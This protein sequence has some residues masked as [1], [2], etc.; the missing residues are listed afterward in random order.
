MGVRRWLSFRR[1]GVLPFAWLKRSSA[2]RSLAC[3][4]S[5]SWVWV[6]TACFLAETQQRGFCGQGDAARELTF[7]AR[8]CPVS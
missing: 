7:R 4:A 6:L 2:A 1:G 5:S 8:S 3:R